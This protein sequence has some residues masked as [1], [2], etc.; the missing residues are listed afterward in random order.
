M[1]KSSKK[2]DKK[3]SGSKTSKKAKDENAD[4]TKYYCGVGPVPKGKVR[5]P[6]EYCIRTNQVRYYGLKQIDPSM[7]EKYKGSSNDLKTEL[8]K[9]KKLEADAKILVNEFK[10][11]KIILDDKD[12]T[13]KKKKKIED[14]ISDI[15]VKKDKLVKKIKTQK[16]LIDTIKEDE[17]QIKKLKK[18]SEKK[19]SSGSKSSKKK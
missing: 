1:S 10:K 9:M 12:I 5:G 14:K 2:T 18:E 17:E 15:V 7:I 13:E 6:M 3:S 8:I 11:L 16:S 4:E 19:K